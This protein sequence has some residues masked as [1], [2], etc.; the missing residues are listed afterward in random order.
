MVKLVDCD[1][2]LACT[3]F[4]SNILCCWHCY[5]APRSG[6]S[7]GGGAGTPDPLPATRDGAAGGAREAGVRGGAGHVAAAPPAT[8]D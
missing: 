1:H 5:L 6:G 7:A 8:L 4:V 2:W 3:T